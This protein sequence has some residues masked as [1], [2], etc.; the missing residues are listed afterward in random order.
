MIESKTAT[1]IERKTRLRIRKSAGR[2]SGEL[3]MVSYGSFSYKAKVIA[4]KS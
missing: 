3:L 2:S 4:L 1:F